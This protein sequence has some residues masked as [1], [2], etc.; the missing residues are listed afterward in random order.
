VEVLDH[1]GQ[2]LIDAVRLL[3]GAL[4]GL[5]V[6]VLAMLACSLALGLAWLHDGYGLIALGLFVIGVLAM[7]VGIVRAI[8]ELRI[9]LEPL[10]FEHEKIEG[11]L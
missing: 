7:M 1:L 5:L 11:T 6:S 8:Q 3:R 4:F 2:R 10:W 9:V